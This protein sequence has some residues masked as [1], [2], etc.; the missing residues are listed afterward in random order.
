MTGLLAA[1]DAQ[2]RG[3]AELRGARDVREIG[4]VAVGVFP[5]GEGFASYR[6][7]A[8]LGERRV[9]SLVN[10]VR[11]HFAA[12]PDVRTAEWKTRGHDIAPGLEAALRDAGF[13][14]EE[15][16]SVMLGDA[17]LLAS[18]VPLPDGV[19]LREIRDAQDIRA[20]ERMQA[21]VFGHDDGDARAEHTIARLAAGE[22]VLLWV[23]EAEGRVISAGRLEPVAGTEF[24]GIWGGA[25]VPQW[26][27][28]GVYRALTAKRAQAALARGLRYLHSDSTEFSRPILERAGMLRATTTT[29]YVWTAKA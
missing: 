22:D 25:T 17:A 18:D 1:Y 14:P 13:E 6:D 7:L 23:A 9:R 19:V 27:G 20:M 8:G 4:P 29:P 11:A 5:G 28:R 16:E 3:V 15:R 12:I 10:Q 26:R 24:A 2:L 21:A